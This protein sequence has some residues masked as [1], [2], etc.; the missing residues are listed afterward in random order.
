MSAV[1]KPRSSNIAFSLLTLYLSVLA[2]HPLIVKACT[3]GALN[4]IQEELAQRISGLRAYENAKRRLRA[5]SNV[6]AAGGEDNNTSN[7]LL[8]ALF[9]VIDKRVLQMSLYGLLVAGPLNHFLY[10]ILFRVFARF[11]KNKKTTFAQLLAQN[12]VISPIL[13]SI[14]I[15]AMAVINGTRSPRD[16]A[17]LIRTRLLGMMKVSWVVFPSVQLIANKFLPPLVWV[18]FFNLVA[19]TFGT[20]MNTLN[21]TRLLRQKVMDDK[22]EEEEEEEKG[23][24]DQ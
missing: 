12:L 20:Y 7:P 4:F 22:K 16:I 13:N 19:F 23:Q 15:S 6:N 24:T 2:R 3:S 9:K 10:N 5:A 14:F 1:S 11:P 17:H 18:P 8:R 21:K